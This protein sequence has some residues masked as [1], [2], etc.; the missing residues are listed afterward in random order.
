MDMSIAEQ[1]DPAQYI[2]FNEFFTRSLKTGMRP[3]DRSS[4][5]IVSPV[6]GSISQIGSITN[7]QLIQAKGMTYTIEDIL[8]GDRESAKLFINGSFTTLYLSPR[9]YHRI[10]MPIDGALNKMSYIPGALFSVSPSA[11]ATIN[12]LFARN[13]RIINLF[14]TA[15]GN[16]ALIM[17]GAIFVG[18]METVWAG[19]ITPVKN[20]PKSVFHYQDEGKVIHIDKGDEMGRFN[21]GSSVIILFENARIKWLN[22]LKPDSP[23]ILNQVIGKP[24]N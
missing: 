19:Q 11:T 13:E 8:G 18:S 2:H 5:T 21:M 24:E 7:N 10:H 9:D 4:N 23:V 17:V 20:R 16:M 22:I 12:G 3:V 14:N 6:D 1:S 15:L